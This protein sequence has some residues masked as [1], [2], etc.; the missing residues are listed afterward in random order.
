M[1]HLSH[2]GLADAPPRGEYSAP[3][4]N[5]AAANL[6]VASSFARLYPLSRTDALE[7]GKRTHAHSGAAAAAKSPPSSTTYPSPCPP[8][9]LVGRRTPLAWLIR[10]CCCCCLTRTHQSP[11]GAIQ[12]RRA[13]PSWLAG[14]NYFLPLTKAKASNNSCPPRPWSG[15]PRRLQRETAIGAQSAP[16]SSNLLRESCSTRIT[17]GRV[18]LMKRAD[19][20]VSSGMPWQPAVRFWN[21]KRGRGRDRVVVHHQHRV[22]LPSFRPHFFLLPK[23]WPAGDDSSPALVVVLDRPPCMSPSRCVLA[24]H[25]WAVGSLA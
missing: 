17:I 7:L 14:K 23:V 15:R 6:G 13:W 19:L 12:S 10:C 21:S 20:P 16:P 5:H 8:L 25:G 9:V 11:R 22:K 4:A 18:S 24:R 2:M 1:A 3:R